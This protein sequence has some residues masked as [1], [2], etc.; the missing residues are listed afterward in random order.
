MLKIIIVESD[1]II[2][3][4]I[5]KVV[6]L[7]SEKYTRRTLV[8]VY[9]TIN[10]KLIEE[11]K[12]KDCKKVYILSINMNKKISGIDLGVMIRKEEGNEEIIYVTRHGKMFETAH[13]RV[14]NINIFIE[15]YHDMENRLYNSLSEIFKKEL[16]F[17]RYCYSNKSSY[18]QIY[19]KNI[20]YIYRDKNIRK[21][22]IVTKN[23]EYIINISLHDILEQLDSRFKFSHRSCIVNTDNI[24]E[25]N[26]KKLYFETLAKEKVY[27]LSKKCKENLILQDIVY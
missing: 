22:V 25:Y 2:Q 4:K 18:F 1:V 10:T 6:D 20:F 8:E 9:D 19:H 7:V 11:I 12:N 24:V 14:P 23:R 27:F 17:N 26:W 13:R 21:S 5:R 15:K 3:Q 16:N